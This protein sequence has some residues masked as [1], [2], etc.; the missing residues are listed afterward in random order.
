MPTVLLTGGTGLIGTRLTELLQQR[1]YQVSYLTRDPRRQVPPGV[2]AYGWDVKSG[3]LDERALREADYLVHL[4]GEGIADE[5][6]TDERRR[7][8]IES[9][10]KSLGLLAQ[11]LREVPHRIQSFVSA[12][13]IGYYGADTGAEWLS[14]Q[15]TPGLDFLAEVVV[16]W[17]EAADELAT[18][19]IRTVKLRLG[20]VLS[21]AGGALAKL[22]VPIRLGAGSP[23]GTGKQY[24]S[25][26]HVD[27][28]AR[29]F[30]EALENPGWSGPYNAVAPKPVTNE[31]LVR[32]AAEVLGKPFW[33]PNVPAWSLK[34]L[35]GEMAVV[36]LGGNYILN[37]RLRLETDFAY[38]FPELRPALVDLLK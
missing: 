16:A 33:A 34:L 36:V 19:G 2:K 26:I 14:E 24:Q 5:R 31:E 38:R 27:D 8:I 35:Y 23:L 30:I 4:A 21:T 13:A 11:K 9:R 15:Y 10:T 12:S 22:L 25:W 3:T 17:E 20:I 7:E 29:L 1:G 28:A 18:L 32:T 37:Q 6:W